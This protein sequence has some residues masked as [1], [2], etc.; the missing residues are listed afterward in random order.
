MF[1]NRTKFLQLRAC[2]GLHGLKW[3]KKLDIGD[4]TLIPAKGKH[5]PMTLVS[6]GAILEDKRIGDDEP[7]FF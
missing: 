4:P 6:L 7:P 1:A 5:K 3:Q 2:T